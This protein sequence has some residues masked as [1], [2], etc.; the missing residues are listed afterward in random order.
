MSLPVPYLSTADRPAAYAISVPPITQQHAL[1]QYRTAMP[2]ARPRPVLAYA[3]L[4]S[5]CFAMS[6]TDLRYASTSLFGNAAHPDYN[7]PT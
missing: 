1:S 7:S 6:G 2:S 5:V 4:L 3:M